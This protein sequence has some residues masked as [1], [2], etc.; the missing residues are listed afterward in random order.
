M[1]KKK[2]YSTAEVANILHISRVAVFKQIKNGTLKAEKIGRNY[3]ISYES[4]SKILG[5]VIGTQKK[6]VIENT[7]NRAFDEY[8]EAFKKLGQE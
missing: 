3:V 8:K 7:I 6:K 2:Y 1:V 5:K 4:V